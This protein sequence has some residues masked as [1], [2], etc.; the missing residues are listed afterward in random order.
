MKWY[1]V[2]KKYDS[3]DTILINDVTTIATAFKIAKI[4]IEELRN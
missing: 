2:L 1:L 4:K 3:D